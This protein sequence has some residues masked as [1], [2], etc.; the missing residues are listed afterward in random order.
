MRVTASLISSGAV[1]ASTGVVVPVS[2]ETDCRNCHA[3]GGLA[4][5]DPGITWSDDQDLEIQTRTNV[6]ILHD[7]EQGTLLVA[8]QPVLCA[9]CHYSAALDLNGTGPAGGQ[10]GNP[11]MSA[12]MHGFHGEQVDALG[13]PIIPPDGTPEET[14]YQCHPGGT[15]QCQRGAMR[16]GGMVCQ[17]CHGGMA[18]VGGKYALLAGGSVD[19]Q[20]DGNPRRPWLDLPRCQ[21]CHTGDAVDHLEGPGYVAAGDGVRLFQ[22]WTAGDNSASP[23]LALN[24]RFAENSGTLYR[25]SRGHGGLACEACHGSTHAVWPNAEL[26]SNDNVTAVQL[27]GHAGTIVECSMCHAAGT[28]GATAKDGPHGMHN[29][30][31]RWVSSH[32]NVY[33]QNKNAC[34]A[35]HGLD[36]RGT[37]LSR[38]FASRTF[39][40]DDKG[41]ILIPTGTEV[42]CNICHGM[43][44]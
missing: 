1:L 18:A 8:S 40:T 5:D 39:K 27:Q 16:T 32:E 33:E 3:T 4:A 20:N 22:A 6:L 26:A 38:A 19:G 10:V 29:V 42:A 17:N 44:D 7:H 15:T 37:P 12:T 31:Q 21:S 11:T 14:C 13:N 2:Q 34:R 24:K 41:T 9:S 23:I 36:L 25:F 35:C 43:P 28:L 30:N